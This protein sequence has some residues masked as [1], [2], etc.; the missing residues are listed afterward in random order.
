MS[1]VLL[2]IEV[3][4][5]ETS[6]GG[7]DLEPKVSSLLILLFPFKFFSNFEGVNRVETVAFDGKSSSSSIVMQMLLQLYFVGL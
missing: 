1:C 7:V 4:S 5:L 2:L 6:F 3:L